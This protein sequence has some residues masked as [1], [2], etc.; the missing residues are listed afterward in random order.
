MLNIKLKNKDH[1]LF[2]GKN[3]TKPISDEAVKKATGKP[4][5]QWRDILK[6]SFTKDDIHKDIVTFLR[7]E[8]GLSHWWA[9][10]VTVD[11]EQYTGKRKIGQTQTADYQTGVRKTMRA[12]AD[13]VWDLL[14][15]NKASS[16]W[17]GEQEIQEF[18][19]GNKYQ[20]KDGKSG[21]IRVI[22]PY[23]HIRLT[24]KL[25]E[26]ENPSTLQI[27]VYS[28]PGKKATIAIHHEKLKDGKIRE[29]MSK[30]WKE[31]LDKIEALL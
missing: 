9:Q 29:Q 23:H 19:Q 28:T 13:D 14:L 24:W 15:S 7:D 3:M 30:H 21:E 2:T 26:W 31:V 6:K 8:Y 20:T 10:S 5:E 22:K 11:F 16:I 12:K 27:R 25:K 18:K 4:W 17:L 1:Y